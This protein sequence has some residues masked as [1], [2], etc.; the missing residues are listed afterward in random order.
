MDLKD[1][2][3][4]NLLKQIHLRKEDQLIDFVASINNMTTDLHRKV[5]DIRGEVDQVI[6]SA[7]RENVPEEIIGEL[8]RL[9]QEIDTKFQL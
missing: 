8:N 9:R 7:S 1:I 4:G 3:T 2:G 5:S 6:K